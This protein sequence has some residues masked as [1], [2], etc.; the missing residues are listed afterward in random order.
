[1]PLFSKK[2]KKLRIPTLIPL[3]NVVFLLL[4]FFMLSGTLKRSDILN[5][6]PPESLTGA[7]AEAP[8]FTILISKD[9]SIAINNKVIPISSLEKEIKIIHNSNPVEEVLIKAD[10]KALSGILSDVI[11]FVRKS[12]IERV[13]I[14]TK[15]IEIPIK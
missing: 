7:N 4:I 15:S 3:I 6:S 14:V 2:Q 1:M 10:G 11:S 13:A 9:N 5:V 12:G 8:E